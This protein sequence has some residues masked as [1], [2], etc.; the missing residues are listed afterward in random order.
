MVRLFL[1]HFFFVLH[2][3]IA[4][5]PENQIRDHGQAFSLPFYFC[6]SLL[7][8]LQ[9]R[10]LDQGPWSGFFFAILFLFFIVIL[11]QTRKPD[12]DHDQA[13]SL[14]FYF[15]HCLY[16]LQTRKLDPWSGFFFGIFFIVTL[17]QTRK[18][19]QIR[20]HGQAF[21][22]PFF[23]VLHC[24]IAS[25][26]KTT[27][28]QGP[29]SGFFFA[30]FLFFIVIII[31][32][33]PENQIRDHGQ[34]FSLPFYFCFSLL[35]CY[36][37]ENQIRDHGQAFSLPFYFVLHC[38]NYCLQ[39][40]KLD[41]GPWSGFFFDHFLCSIVTII[42]YRPENQI[43]DHGQ[44]FSLPFQFSVLHC[45]NCL[46][47]RKLDQGPWSGFFFAILF[48]FFIVILLTDQKTRSGTMV[49]LFLC[50]FIF[51]LHCYIATDQKT[52]SG[53]MV[54]LFLWHFLY[55]HCYIATDQKTTVDQGD[56]GQAFSLPFQFLFFIVIIAYR[57]ENQIRDHGQ[58]FSLPFSFCSSLL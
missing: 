20:D 18:L 7:Y 27:V 31:A 41:Q 36:R 9:T 23:F 44:A 28:D 52:R 5:R 14:S 43:R 58:A 13:F 1:C 46:Q 10:K 40:R 19:L 6:S 55:V 54:R 57:P 11:L 12:R 38:Y 17:L 34:A 47:T 32:Y 22:L 25:D 3:Y 49:R 24:Y 48:L 50:H 8:C 2:C 29:W 4:Y 16:C 33:R 39:T 30:I 53:T 21:S 42:A 15:H 35:Y 45:Y 26:Q 51:V 37:P 56:H